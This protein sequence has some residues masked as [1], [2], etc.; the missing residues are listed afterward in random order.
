MR[1]I[2]YVIRAKEETRANISF[3]FYSE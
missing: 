1:W 3:R 2:A